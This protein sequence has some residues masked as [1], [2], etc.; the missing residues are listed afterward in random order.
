MKKK[1]SNGAARRSAGRRKKARPGPA[2]ATG[3]HIAALIDT[4]RC[5][6]GCIGCN[7]CRRLQRVG[8]RIADNAYRYGMAA[9]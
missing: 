9:R 7:D 1:A 4:L 2:P 5:I 3:A 8:L 6:E